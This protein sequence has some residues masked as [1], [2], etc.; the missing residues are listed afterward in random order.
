MRTLYRS[1]LAVLLLL[2]VHQA[3]R[4]QAPDSFNYQAVARDAGGDPLVSQS[5]SVLFQLHQGTAAG[6]VVFAETHSTS[7]SAQGL[8][9]LQ[10]GTGTPQVGSMSAVNWASGPYFMEVGLDAT[11]GSAHVSMGTQQLLS[12]PYALFAQRTPC[13]STS[14]LGDTLYT[15]NG[16]FV[17]IPGVSAANG[18]CLDLDN[19]GFYDRPG[20]G[21][22]DCND[23]MAAVFPGAMELCGDGLDNNCD[24]AI[25]D[26]T[27]PMAFAPWFADTDGD[28]FGDNASSVLAC[29]QPPGFVADNHDCNDADPMVYPG[30]GCSV[31]CGQADADWIAQHQV[32]YV[33]AM[34]DAFLNCFMNNM[35]NDETC[36][37]NE[38]AQLTGVSFDCNTCGYQLSQCFLAPCLGSCQGGL[39]DACLQCI[40]Q[41][42]CLGQFA[43]CVAFIDVDNDGW[44]AGSDCNDNDPS[45]WPAGPEIC[46]DGV[47]NNCNGQVDENT[48]TWYVDA[49]ADGYGDPATGVQACTGPMGT[50]S[51]GGD[52]DD[53]D[54]NLNPGAPELCNGT[55]DNCDGAIDNDPVDG[56]VWYPDADGDG[57]GDD[58]G[59][60]FACT[61]PAGYVAQ[62]GDCSDFDP[63]IFPGAM[64]VCDGQDND[65]DG[66]V[67]EDFDLLSDPNNCG[68]C[69]NACTMPNA[70][71][72][73]V[74][75]MCSFTCLPAGTPCS[76]GDPCTSGDVTDGAC[77]CFG[78]PVQNGGSCD[79]GDPCTTGDVCSGGVC[80]GNPVGVDADLDGFT[81]CGGDC[82]DQNPQVYPGA[83]ELCD[84]V[85][86]DCDGLVDEDCPVGMPCDGPDADQCANG[87]FVCGPMG[88]CI[89][90]EMGAGNAETCGDGM[91]NDCDGMVDEGCGFFDLDQ[92]G[93]LDDVDCNDQDPG[94]FPGAPEQ[95]DGQD[96]DCDGQIDEGGVCSTVDQ[97][98]DGF[99]A[100]MDCD[101]LNPMVNPGAIEQCDGIDNDCDGMVDEGCACPPAGTPCDDGNPCTA[102]EVQDGACNCISGMFLPSGAAAGPQIAGDCQTL[103]CD[104]MG[105]VTSQ[106]DNADV[107]LDGNDCTLDVCVAGMPANQPSPAGTSCMGGTCDGM[108]TCVQTCTDNDLDGSTTCA[109]DCDDSDPMINPGA[110]EVCSNGIDDDCDGQVDEG[111][112]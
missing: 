71:G 81:D 89:C 43:D 53:Q 36:I 72:I 42:G 97:D 13:F 8:I 56:P 9:N 59:A 2:A 110:T 100:N 77:G 12:V 15:G 49:D 10:V 28:G 25:D 30:N 112:P 52:C 79:D 21:P 3:A 63:S 62:G 20:C 17:I 23:T 32:A 7:T 103:V 44:A 38:L 64:E 88:E 84:G 50:V 18:G 14:L 92:D 34:G 54:P 105:G 107:P 78:T 1:F 58:N 111:C 80:S 74:M 66:Q 93:S 24:G 19:D 27:D 83:F 47:D 26:L 65:C 101:D 57:S 76:D 46:G 70:V 109:G 96:N 108:G 55:D 87:V 39:T 90:N 51:N 45:V 69:G 67:D 41:S 35:G 31:L 40:T 6:P 4:S 98:G 29:A 86:N 99:A 5:V 48:P 16:C 60:V 73:C 91:D 95:C 85:D 68:W 11:G 104:G 61:Q 82:N 22:V 33:Q 102:G 75:G 94:T 37:S 106:A